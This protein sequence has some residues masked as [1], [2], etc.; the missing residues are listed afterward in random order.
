MLGVI[1]D[2]ERGA[3]FVVKGLNSPIESELITVRG[4]ISLLE[5]IKFVMSKPLDGG[6]PDSFLENIAK[7]MFL[8]TKSGYAAPEECVIFDSAWENILKQSDAPTIDA[9]SYGVDIFVYKDQLR[10]IGVKVDPMDVFSLASFLTDRDN[11]N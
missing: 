8:K 11:I 4:M 10:A 5:C 2:F 3:S 1:T 7:S 9:K 6:L